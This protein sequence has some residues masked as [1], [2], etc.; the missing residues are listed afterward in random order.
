[1]KKSPKDGE[2]E[3]KISVAAVTGFV[4][5]AVFLIVSVIAWMNIYSF[6]DA[7]DSASVWMNLFR[8]SLAG[9]VAALIAS[10]AGVVI[11]KVK[12][13]NGKEIGVTGIITSAVGIA[14]NI[15]AYAIFL[16]M[17]AGSV[18][19]GNPQ[20]NTGPE[21][22][23]PTS[24]RN[25]F[26][27]TTIPDDIT[28]EIMTCIYGYGPE[29]ITLWS[30]MD[31]VPSMV[32]MYVGLHPEF[33]EKYSV[34]CT[35]LTTDYNYQKA[36][37]NALTGGGD[38]APDIYVVEASYAAKYTKG[39]MSEYAAAYEDLGID[40]ETKIMEAD[41]AS[42]IVDVGSRNDEVVGLS[43]AANS[44][45][46][47]YRASIAR[48]VFGTDDPVDIERLLG[49]GSG[50]WDKFWIAAEMLKSYGYPIVTGSEEVWMVMEGNAES[51][52]ITED[53]ALF[54]DPRREEFLDYAK[55]IRTNNWSNNARVWSDQW[56]RDMCDENGCFCF[57][58]P[59][60]MIQ[61][62][63]SGW[64]TTGTGAGTFG[65]WRVCTPPEGFFW[66]G[67]WLLANRDTDNKEG[68]AE[69]LEWFTLD[70][71][72][73]GLQYYLANGMLGDG[74]KDTVASNTVMR[75]CDGSD[76]FCGGQDVFPVFAECSY[77]ASGMVY[78]EYDELI[79][80]IWVYYAYE[81][82][83]GHIKRNDVINVFTND[84]YS[85]LKLGQG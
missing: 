29:H 38:E 83:E 53:G 51:G 20:D 54:V 82:A 35:I 62:I 15:A 42:F 11:S 77:F 68:V 28:P 2:T 16:N 59:Y 26:M 21:E 79:G 40:V 49:G 5:S 6:S 13:R 67:S 14:A 39:S 57:F 52:W 12:D 24:G 74:Y 60:W 69:L 37:D 27:E 65:D 45:A 56:Y 70:F 80:A 17:V 73:T 75:M 33:A 85:E 46:M 34:E 81:Y 78:S 18:T 55:D 50:S 64:S 47:I 76:P 84:V 19:V 3:K 7:E 48:E 22:T 63:M 32:E 66:G 58:G 36:L 44:G 43:Y 31:E 8:I 72:D 23:E 4:L 25:Y 9:T 1:M 71:S 10:A 41:I 30:Y 61:Y